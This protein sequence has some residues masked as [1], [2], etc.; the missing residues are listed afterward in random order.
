MKYLIVPL[1]IV[2]LPIYSF[3]QSNYYVTDS[4]TIVGVSLIDGGDIVNSQLCQIEKYDRVE[5]FT[6]EEVIEYGF[7]DGR[8]YVSKEVMI[9]GVLKRVFLEQLVRGKKSLYYYRGKKIKTFFIQKD[10][11][12]F[13]EITKNGYSKKNYSEQ[14]I[15]LTKDCPNVLNA[16]KLTSYNK[17]TLT[18]LF[19]RYNK[20]EFKPF[21]HIKFGVLIGYE[22]VK[23][24]L[25]KE[26]VYEVSKLIPSGKEE[27]ELKYFDF[28]YDGGFLLGI[29]IDKPISASDFSFHMEL[30]F[31]KHNYSY[32]RVEN[33]INFD[34]V[35]KFTSINIPIQLRYV[36]PSNKIRPYVNTGIVGM[37]LVKNKYSLYK[38]LLNNKIIEVE[39]V[40]TKPMISNMQIGYVIGGG[41]EYNLNYRK[42]IFM[43]LRYKS[44]YN[45]RDYEFRGTSAFSLQIG[46]NF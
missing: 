41:F 20:C 31:G 21:P 40:E 33:D 45:N 44:L 39:N 43:E 11:T 29:F 25:T 36:Y 19:Q 12:L 30:L 6:P 13:T 32:N 35:T 16:C 26:K 4:L 22:M 8:V 17:K 34:F 10:S 1:L 18:K 9:N 15:S 24:I 7:K 28:R 42:S 38:E 5:Q 3:G 46:I 23:L 37:Y 14:L 27:N 2:L